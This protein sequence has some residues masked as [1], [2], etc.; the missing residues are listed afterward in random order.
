MKRSKIIILFASVFCAMC[1]LAAVSCKDGSETLYGFDVAETIVVDAGENVLVD[2]PI[3]TDKDGVPFDVYYEVTTADGDFVGV[4]ANRFF[5]TESTGYYINYAVKAKDGSVYRK[6]TFVKVNGNSGLSAEYDI[7]SEQGEEVSVCPVTDLQDAIFRYSVT[8]KETGAEV[9]VSEEGKFVT[10]EPGFYT[11][12][13]FAEGGGTELEYEYEIYCREPMIEGEVERF[14]EEWAEIRSLNGM[15]TF[16]W[17]V[18]DTAETGVKDRFGR[19]ATY[20]KT[21]TSAEYGYF[22]IDP[23]ADGD[24]YR[25]LAKEGYTHVSF[26]IYCDSDVNHDVMSQF[27]PEKGA[28]TETVGKIVPNVWTEIKVR[29]V[30]TYVDYAGSFASAVDYYKKQRTYILCFDNTAGWNSGGHEENM[31]VYIGDVYA[32]KPAELSVAD[33]AALDYKTGESISFEQLVS[34]PDGIETGYALSFRNEITE[35]PAGENYRFA[36]NGEYMVTVIPAPNIST[37]LSFTVRVTDDITAETAKTVFE[38]TEDSLTISFSALGAE[39]KNGGE[40]VSRAGCNV[41]RNG[42]EIPAGENSV[43][44]DTDGVYTF[45]FV[46]KYEKDGSECTVYYEIPVD[47][48]SEENKYIVTG[49]DLMLAHS[50]YC[51]WQNW[52]THPV[53]ENGAFTVAGTSGRMFK[54]TKLGNSF[55][56]LFLPMYSKNYYETLLAEDVSATVTLKYYVES[57][58]TGGDIRSYFDDFENREIVRNQWVIETVPL[59]EFIA[60][61]DKLSAGYEDVKY[62]MEHN[63]AQTHSRER[64]DFL[65]WVNGDQINDVIYIPDI[66]VTTEATEGSAQPKDG[67]QL[68]L[69]EK[70]DLSSMIGITLDGKRAEIGKA[71]V[72]YGD[73]WTDLAD[74]T[75]APAFAGEY[76]FRLYAV[77]GNVYKTLECK[78]RTEGSALEKK[79]DTSLHILKK[80]GSFDLSEYVLK[81]Y[82]VEYKVEKIVGSFAQTQNCTIENDTITWDTFGGRGCYRITVTLLADLPGAFGEFEYYTLFID[83]VDG[84][85]EYISAEDGAE[86]YVFGWNDWGNAEA[87]YVSAELADGTEDALSGKTGKY[88]KAEIAPRWAHSLDEVGVQIL[89]LYSKAYYESLLE[90]GEYTLTFEW[91]YDLTFRYGTDPGAFQYKVF[92]AEKGYDGE[93]S[94]W[95]GAS[96]SLRDLIEKWDTLT[97]VSK[98]G[99]NRAERDLLYIRAMG[100]NAHNEVVGTLYIGNFVLTKTEVSG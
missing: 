16:G 41:Y 29:L 14:S 91:R 8:Y 52:D 54:V 32:V 67:A 25:R 38:R 18:T 59:S 57:S 78:L 85:A 40:T 12:E 49:G 58:N 71:E 36:A 56:V 45:E 23:R 92:G 28:Y 70:N 89:P 64:Q 86:A 21:V 97:S 98:A 84:D 6:S 87:P 39:L 65:F 55:L 100:G 80:G 72:F 47:I 82:D 48:W 15:D 5:A 17:E 2:I 51:G 31:T 9:P 33:G 83:A 88:F 19:D 77:A 63:I 66:A 11:V 68:V 53:Y 34:N 95:Y 61:Y 93:P 60:D 3:V 35:I 22:W 62:L 81:G 42:E 26:W 96:V 90:E 79:E 7:F 44:I 69:G 50:E 4:S 94:V 74:K 20:L 73:I 27:Y 46:G 24:Y 13:I 75:F 30:E 43:T 76:T 99:G 1:A 10:K 37:D